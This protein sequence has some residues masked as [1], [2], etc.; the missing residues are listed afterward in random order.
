MATQTETPD[1]AHKGKR[2]NPYVKPRNPFVDGSLVPLNAFNEQASTEFCDHAPV[3]CIQKAPN[4]PCRSQ[5]LQRL[6]NAKPV[7]GGSTKE[8]KQNPLY[9]ALVEAGCPETRATMLIHEEGRGMDTAPALIRAYKLEK[10]LADAAINEPAKLKMCQQCK[11]STNT[12]AW[13]DGYKPNTSCRRIPLKEARGGDLAADGK[14]LCIGRNGRLAYCRAGQF[15]SVSHVWS[16]GWQGFREDGICSRVLEMLLDV[17][18]KHGV[19]YVWLDVAMISSQKELRAKVINSMND[20]YSKAK[21]TLVCDRLMILLDTNDNRERALALGASDWWKRLWTM[22]EAFLS[23]ALLVLCRR[24]ERSWHPR[25]V[26]RNLDI[27][28]PIEQAWT[29]WGAIRSLASIRDLSKQDRM[30]DRVVLASRYR[31]TSKTVDLARALFPLFGLEWPGYGTTLEQGQMLLLKRLGR[32]ASR[33]AHIMGP[34][35]LPHP[36][37][38]APKTITGTVGP[39]SSLGPDVTSRGLQGIFSYCE[40]EV[41][42]YV[43]FKRNVN[44]PDPITES[45]ISALPGIAKQY[46]KNG[47]VG[48]FGLSSSRGLSRTVRDIVQDRFT[49]ESNDGRGTTLDALKM[50]VAMDIFHTAG[51]KN[52]KWKDGDKH[53]NVGEE[54]YHMEEYALDM[55]NNMCMVILRAK[56]SHAL[57]SGTLLHPMNDPHPW[58]RKP[59]ILLDAEDPGMN[60]RRSS[61]TCSLTTVGDEGDDGFMSLH[62]V[63]AFQSSHRMPMRKGMRAVLN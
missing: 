36:F 58:D 43:P 48:N 26:I 17:A 52:A 30:L 14:V 11:P 3:P 57:C 54:M 32:Q 18:E 40:V 1:G 49:S 23:N 24:S 60:E 28:K 53:E 45:H 2:R 27:D 7:H 13:F 39:L 61:F 29:S 63:G 16:H 21:F 55:E 44:M 15:M 20:I 41:I 38:W 31:A 25:H 10:Q 35:G 47:T 12:Y 22:Q 34:L 9:S 33:L 56:S 51:M 8:R 19:E 46:F 59:L 5:E 37:A 42:S 50:Q 4:E 62:K 6:W